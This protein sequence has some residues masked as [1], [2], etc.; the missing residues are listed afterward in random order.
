MNIRR[1]QYW[2]KE[3]TRGVDAHGSRVKRRC[4][5]FWLA[6]RKKQMP[7]RILH[8]IHG[9]RMA[10]VESEVLHQLVLG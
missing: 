7:T 2:Q 10:A 4:G 8:E 6:L 5:E 9:R 1:T 3:S